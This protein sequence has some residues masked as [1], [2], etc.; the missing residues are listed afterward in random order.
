VNTPESPA[1]FRCEDCGDLFDVSARQ[2]RTIRR[3]GEGYCCQRCRALRRRRPR[4]KVSAAERQYWIDRFGV[5]G[6]SE[7]AMA[8]WGPVRAAPTRKSEVEYM[9]ASGNEH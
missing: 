8:I 1:A 5:A 4:S 7:L 9:A 3:V 2:A 6:A